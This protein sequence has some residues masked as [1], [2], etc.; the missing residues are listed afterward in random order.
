MGFVVSRHIGDFGNVKNVEGQGINVVLTDPVASLAGPNSILNKT[1]VVRTQF[2]WPFN[3]FTTLQ[4][5]VDS[6]KR[7]RPDAYG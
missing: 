1:L 5:F 7:G 2:G 3:G 4:K 6:R